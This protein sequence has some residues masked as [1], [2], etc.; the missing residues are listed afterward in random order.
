MFVLE[1]GPAY[2][3]WKSNPSSQSSCPMIQPGINSEKRGNKVRIGFSYRQSGDR[4]WKDARTGDTDG[5]MGIGIT[6]E[7]KKKI[8]A[9]FGG[10]LETD[11][12]SL[13]KITHQAWLFAIVE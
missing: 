1:D 13:P 9:P 7:D 12:M 8:N 5:S 4:C 10:W 3:A 2:A 6:T 11:S